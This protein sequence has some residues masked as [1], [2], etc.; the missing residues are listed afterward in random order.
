MA[1]KFAQIT[2]TPA[3]QAA[4]DKYFGRHHVVVDAPERDELTLEESDFVGA[5]DSFYMATT[6]SDGWPYIQHR[7]G[8]T[9]FLKVLSPHLLGFAD[10]KGNRQLLT[11][12]NLEGDNRVALFLMDYPKQ[13]RLKIL[14]HAQVFD[15]REHRDLADRLS[16]GPEWRSKIER[17]FLIEVVSFDWN[18]PQYITPRFTAAQV[19]EAVQP[20]KDRIEALEKQLREAASANGRQ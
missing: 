2:L 11:T 12:G 3:V 15:A 7:G 16:P 9:G 17:L 14:G 8:P 13:E 20:L 4:Q 6:N 19:Q 18:C 1:A 10:F 5:R